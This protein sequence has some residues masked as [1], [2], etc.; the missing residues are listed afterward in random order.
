MINVELEELLENYLTGIISFEGPMGTSKSTTAVAIAYEKF[1]VLGRKVISNQH[2]SFPYSRFDIAYFLEHYADEELTNCVLLMDEFY[3][4]ADARASA[5]KLNRLW[6]YFIVQ[7][8]KRDVDLFICT[9]HLDHIDKRN[10]RA[11]NIRGSCRYYEEYPCKKCRGTGRYPV[12]GEVIKSKS[13][14]RYEGGDQCP[15]CLGYGKVG[16]GRVN[17]LDRRRR[18]RYPVEIPSNMYW[19][20]FETR[21]RV[22][23]QQK[24]L[25]GIDT[26]EV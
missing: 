7:T 6:T 21:E 2:L 3:Q 26:V 23:V 18:I 25:E 24:I 17:F 20:K 1:R 15:R 4:I 5:T 14:K 22:S 19:D 13:Y 9:H 10:R 11:V 16:Y 12:Q 8:R